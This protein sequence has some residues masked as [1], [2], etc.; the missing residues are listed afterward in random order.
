MRGVVVVATL[1]LVATVLSSECTGLPPAVLSLRE[2]AG[3][4][5]DKATEWLASIEKSVD[6]IALENAGL[7]GKKK[8]GEALDMYRALLARSSLSEEQVAVVRQHLERLVAYTRLPEYHNV[9]TMS[10]KTLQEGS[11]SYLRVLSLIRELG[12]FDSDAKSYLEQVRLAKPRL[13]AHLPGRGVWQKRQFATYYEKFG[14]EMPRV[15]LDAKAGVRSAP[16]PIE[17]RTRPADYTRDQE[18]ELTHL[19]FAAYDYGRWRTQV[20]LSESALEYL[21]TA[22]PELLDRAV[23]KNDVDIAAEYVMSLCYLGWTDV[24]AFERG[25]KYLL[26]AQNPNGSWGDYEKFR[27]HYG[28]FIDAFGYLHTVGVSSEALVHVFEVGC[29]SC[30][31]KPRPYGPERL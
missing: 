17:R 7:K 1:A 3:G 14:L 31:V 2:Q 12:G 26:K 28:N 19:V 10:D 30:E 5:L 24:P 13:D 21:R 29:G 4:A 22:L 8:L 20:Q 9:R 25:V 15:L 18:Y 6:P 16:T 27:P 11:M 23:G